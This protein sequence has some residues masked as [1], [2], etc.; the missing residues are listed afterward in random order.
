MS[1]T[2]GQRYKDCDFPDCPEKGRVLA[3]MSGIEIAYCPTHRKKYGERIVSALIN[4]RFNYKLSNFLTEVRTKIFMSDD[5]LSEESG[6]KLKAY[7]IQKSVELDEILKWAD[8][9]EAEFSD[10]DELK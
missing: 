7:V 5:I 6:S 8:E 3:R 2:K 4:S 1:K 10:K 9:N